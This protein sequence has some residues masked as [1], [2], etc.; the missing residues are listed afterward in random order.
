MKYD[1]ELNI[2]KC[3]VDL[4]G[5]AWN[6][7][8]YAALDQRIALEPHHMRPQWGNRPAFENQV[9]SHLSNL[10]DK[11]QLLK[12]RSGLHVITQ[13]GNARANSN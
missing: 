4:G 12:I 10:C 9:R 7:K 13:T 11:H 3:F 1:W 5:H 2:L 8:L 6:Y